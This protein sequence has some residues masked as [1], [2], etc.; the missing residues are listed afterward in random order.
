M[1]DINGPSIH[2]GNRESETILQTLGEERQ[3]GAP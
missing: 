2:P 3:K 1:V